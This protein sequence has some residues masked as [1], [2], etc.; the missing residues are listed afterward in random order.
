ML[1]LHLCMTGSKG[2]AG[3]LPAAAQAQE[4]AA[5]APGPVLPGLCAANAP[6]SDGPLGFQRN[7]SAMLAARAERKQQAL[8]RIETKLETPTGQC[9]L[10]CRGMA[11]LHAPCVA[12]FGVSHL[13][14]CL[15]L[16]RGAYCAS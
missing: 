13:A 6:L 2:T 8:P 7:S 16:S 15:A 9:G 4:A 3:L 12:P 1:T 14:M 11:H 5:I 10:G